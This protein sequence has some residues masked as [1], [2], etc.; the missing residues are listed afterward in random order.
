MVTTVVLL[1]LFQCAVR[2][3]SEAGVQAATAG[4]SEETLSGPGIAGVE[5]G[6]DL[7]GSD[8]HRD[9]P[10]RESRSFL[11][12]TGVNP[13]LPHQAPTELLTARRLAEGG[14]R[15]GA[16]DGGGSS[17]G[18]GVSS[19][20][21]SLERLSLGEQQ[22][23][24]P[25]S[26]PA[27]SAGFLS[28]PP[29]PGSP[30][31][32][33]HSGSLPTLQAR[34]VDTLG[35]PPD[36]HPPQQRLMCEPCRQLG[37]ITQALPILQE[38]RRDYVRLKD[39]QEARLLGLFRRAVEESRSP[40]APPDAAAR[41]DEFHRLLQ[42]VRRDRTEALEEFARRERPLRDAVRV[43]ARSQ[44]ALWRR[45]GRLLEHRL[46]EAQRHREHAQAAAQFEIQQRVGD[47][48]AQ[49]GQI[50]Q[51]IAQGSGD[52]AALRQ[53]EANLHGEIQRQQGRQVL[54]PRGERKGAPR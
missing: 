49:L 31:P 24:R 32:R 33:R 10:V 45:E 6:S 39:E 25:L 38:Q 47:L 1:F 28:R 3:A 27:A 19:T 29:S 5:A 51:Q 42:S 22:P 12:P 13:P 34:A 37:W 41:R 23:P 20:R 26:P 43:F 36:P 16:G 52:L 17:G 40:H 50:Q 8:S 48:M 18:R 54:G 44:A 21:R 30:S 46:R 11:S 14:S 35:L 15:K 53:Q 2:D 4:E 9:A 7:T